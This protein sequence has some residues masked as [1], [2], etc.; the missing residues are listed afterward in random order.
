MKLP[1]IL[2]YAVT[3][4][5]SGAVSALISR[6]KYKK[7]LKTIDNNNDSTV[8]SNIEKG[9]GILG[10]ML[11][12]LEERCRKNQEALKSEIVALNVAKDELSHKVRQLE[13][14]IEDLQDEMEDERQEFRMEIKKLRDAINN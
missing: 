11:D 7:E 9:A 2:S 5:G 6:S 12:D 14:F 4:L 1:E 8:I 10:D 13:K 3:I